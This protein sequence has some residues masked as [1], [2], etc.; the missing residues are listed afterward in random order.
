MTFEELR[1]RL[2]EFAE[3]REWEQFHTP[4]NL[5]LALVGEVGELA[6]LFQWRTDDEIRVLAGEPEG[7]RA[8]ADELAD[9]LF[10]LV[11]LADV[12]G[13]TLESAATE[14]LVANGVRYAAED[15]RGSA[16]KRPPLEDIGVV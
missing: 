10:Y 16:A 6:E 13:I 1:V 2:R 4:R 7:M 14:K 5:A 11:R 12:L 8:V 9:V 15:V 3:D